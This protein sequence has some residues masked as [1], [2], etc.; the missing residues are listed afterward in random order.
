MSKLFFLVLPLVLVLSA[1]NHPDG[2]LS[3]EQVCNR[4]VQAFAAEFGQPDTTTTTSTS[5]TLWYQVR[6]DARVQ[7]EWYTQKYEKFDWA[8]GV[9]V[10]TGNMVN[11][12]AS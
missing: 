4:E 2:P 1:C 11:T 8:T 7:T 3:G 6:D 10:I 9:C 12:P 5:I